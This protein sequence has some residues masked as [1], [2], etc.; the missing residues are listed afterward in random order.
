M[1]K[2]LRD[3]HAA[4]G[5]GESGVAVSGRYILWMMVN[6]PRTSPSE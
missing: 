6:A 2:G 4:L 3:T 1:K 5:E